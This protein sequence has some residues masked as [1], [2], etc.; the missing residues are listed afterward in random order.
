MILLVVDVFSHGFG[1]LTERQMAL[2][3]ISIVIVIECSG[4]NMFVLRE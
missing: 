2:G 4:A 3:N 1:L